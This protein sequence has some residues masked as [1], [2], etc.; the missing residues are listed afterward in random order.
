MRQIPSPVLKHDR[1]I[2]RRE[3]AERKRARRQAKLAA[4]KPQRDAAQG[5]TA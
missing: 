3:K 2:K 4:R 5:V 1:E